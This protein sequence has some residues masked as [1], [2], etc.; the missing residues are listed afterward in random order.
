MKKSLAADLVTIAVGTVVVVGAMVL[1]SRRKAAPPTVE[2]FRGLGAFPQQQGS[3][4]AN[5]PRA[6]QNLTFNQL[7]QQEPL[8]SPGTVQAIEQYLAGEPDVVASLPQNMAFNRWRRG[9]GDFGGNI[10]GLLAATT[11]R[12]QLMGSLV[13]TQYD[14]V[15]HALW[16]DTAQAMNELPQEVSHPG[17][18][19]SRGV[20]GEAMIPAPQFWAYMQSNGESPV[21][22]QTPFE[23]GLHYA[24]VW[25]GTE[26]VM[27]LERIG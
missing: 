10:E 19:I 1:V 6:L 3:Y 8:D 25:N 18:V 13:D 27:H 23:Q 15:P 7:R 9:G 17:D 16:N 4:Y 5:T 2:G 24:P 21:E 12:D 26:R 11:G 14:R 22:Y 20:P